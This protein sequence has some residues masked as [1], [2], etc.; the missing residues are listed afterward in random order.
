MQTTGVDALTA[1][2]ARDLTPRCQAPS[3]GLGED[4]CS[5]PP[6][7]RG[8]V[9]LHHSTL[10]PRGFLLCG[11]PFSLLPFTRACVIGLRAH[12]NNPERSGLKINLMTSAMTLF[13]NKVTVRGS[14]IN[15]TIWEATAQPTTPSVY[16]VPGPVLSSISSSQPVYNIGTAVVPI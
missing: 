8:C 1:L 7:S 16:P 15:I 13:P 2:T 4:P 14:C 6:A 11:P 12:P 5:P 3:R 10:S 9:W